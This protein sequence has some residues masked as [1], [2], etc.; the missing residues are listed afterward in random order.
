[1][2]DAL[3]VGPSDLSATLE[4]PGDLE[5]PSVAEAITRAADSV[6]GRS[7]PLGMFC[8]GAE[9]PGRS[10]RGDGRGVTML[11]ISTDLMACSERGQWT[12]SMLGRGHPLALREDLRDESA[13]S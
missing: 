13:R 9:A 8:P 11:V 7:V 5:H 2:F 4:H 6:L 3:F 1:M 10:R 12:S